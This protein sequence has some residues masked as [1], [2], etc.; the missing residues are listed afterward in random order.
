MRLVQPLRRQIAA[1][2]F[3]VRRQVA[4][5]VDQLQTFAESDAVRDELLFI[6]PRAGKKMRPAELRPK[7]ADAAGD[8]ISVLVQFGG[9][10]KRDDFLGERTRDACAPVSY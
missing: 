4:Q 2:V 8:A 9:G 7:F 10:F 6:Q 3:Q 1:A 5:N